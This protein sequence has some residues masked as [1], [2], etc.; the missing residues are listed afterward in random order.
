MLTMAFRI[1]KNLRMQAV[2]ATFLALPA[3]QRRSSQA[4]STELYRTATRVLMYKVARTCAR[5]PQMVRV[6]RRVPLS[7]LN[8]A[9]VPRRLQA[10]VRLGVPRGLRVGAPIDCNPRLV[11]PA[12]RSAP[13]PRSHTHAY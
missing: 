3:A 11:P 9:T 7:R 4:L 13:P 2:K 10:V 5:P 8:G 6:P 12:A 1:V